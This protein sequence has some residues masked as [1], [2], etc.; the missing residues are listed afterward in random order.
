MKFFPPP[1][2]NHCSF[3]E[4][5]RDNSYSFLPCVLCTFS[6]HGTKSGWIDDGRTNGGGV[7]EDDSV[8]VCVLNVDCRGLLDAG[9]KSSSWISS[10]LV[11]PIKANE[12]APPMQITNLCERTRKCGRQARL[13]GGF[14]R[15]EKSQSGISSSRHTHFIFR[16]FRL[17]RSE[18]PDRV[19]RQAQRI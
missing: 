12:G 15:V 16:H 5:L 14:I 3:W 17:E 2:S 8:C 13:R 6:K 7:D 10:F 4:S 11:P 9:K 1:P 19:P 18:Q